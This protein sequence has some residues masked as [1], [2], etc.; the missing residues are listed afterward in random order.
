[1]S[2]RKGHWCPLC[3]SKSRGEKTVLSDGLE[4]CRSVAARRGGRVLSATYLGSQTHISVECDSGHQWQITPS[5]LWRGKWCPYCSGNKVMN[6]LSIL[7]E[8]ASGRGGRLVTD[9]YLGSNVR[10]EWE[11]SAGHHWRATPGSI[12][13][14]SWCPRCAGFKSKP[15]WFDLM[16]KTVTNR[17]GKLLSAMGSFKGPRKPNVLVECSKGHRWRTCCYNLVSEGHWCKRC[18]LSSSVRKLTLQDMHNLGVKH[19]GK[20]LSENYVNS[21]THLE[22]ECGLGHRWKAKPSNVGSGRWCPVCKGEILSARF[23]RKAS[24]SFYDSIAESR[25]GKLLTVDEPRNSHQ[26]LLWQCARGHRWKAKA[27]NIQN[28]KWCPTCSSGY[29]ERICR[30]YFE[31]LFCRNFP[32]TWPEWLVIKGTRR[33]LD[34]YCPELG[35][36][37][38]HQGEQHYSEML[39]SHFARTPLS[40][41]KAVDRRKIVLCRRNG[42]KLIQVPEIPRLTKLEDLRQFIYTECRKNGV[43]IP[44]DFFTRPINLSRAWNFNLIERLTAAATARGGKCLSDEFVGLHRKYLWECT[45]GHRWQAAGSSVIHRKSWCPQCH[46]AKL[47]KRSRDQA[48]V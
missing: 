4:R 41:R 42:V 14:G 31:D 44:E 2:V 9:D 23:R 28:G 10:H 37:F 8:L 19:G 20:C 12:K 27:N 30:A 22:W 40:H 29:G 36:S 48:G 21:S 26:A 33:Q 46:F 39:G 16:A 18:R 34:G 3:A 32:S 47:R 24:I 43:E 5:N 25:G 17:G 45:V 35:L 6:P 38:E 13:N 7:S 11:C 1:M 15:E